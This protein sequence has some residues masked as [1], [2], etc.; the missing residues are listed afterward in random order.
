M[1]YFHP[2]SKTLS[3]IL[4]PTQL[5]CDLK[6]KFRIAEPILKSVFVRNTHP[7][8][9]T[10]HEVISQHFVVL[11]REVSAISLK[12]WYLDLDVRDHATGIG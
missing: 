3:T 5:S 2:K 9:A 7:F 12:Y 4:R 1:H 11:S 10:I 8:L 6:E